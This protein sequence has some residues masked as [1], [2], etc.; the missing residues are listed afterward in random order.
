[1]SRQESNPSK[2]REFTIKDLDQVITINKKCLPENYPSGFFIDIYER[3][4]KSFLVSEIVKSKE[5]IGYIMG[6]IER[7]LSNYG[8]RLTKKGHIVSVAVLHEYRKNG[9]GYDLVSKSLEAMRDYGAAEIVL[10]VRESN[11]AAIALYKKL[12]FENSKTLKGYYSDGE[13]AYLMS[14]RLQP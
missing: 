1:M 12:T 7:G 4:P 3:F 10:E 5:V 13:D 2:T 8:F 6:R 11:I 14:K 9:V